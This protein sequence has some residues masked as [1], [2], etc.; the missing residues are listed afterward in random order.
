MPWPSQQCNDVA[1]L[2]LLL[3]ENNIARVQTSPL[4]S[5]ESIGLCSIFWNYI[6]TRQKSFQ[7]LLLQNI[8]I[9]RESEL[10]E[11]NWGFFLWFC[12]LRVLW[13]L[14]VDNSSLNC[15]ILKWSGFQK[16]TP[17]LFHFSQCCE[18]HYSNKHRRIHKQDYLVWASWKSIQYC[19]SCRSQWIW[20]VLWA[21]CAACSFPNFGSNRKPAIIFHEPCSKWINWR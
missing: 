14:Q 8:C 1:I 11:C 19:F 5:F 13:L 3:R 10:G 17:R 20:F 18:N 15:T 16:S 7:G 6:E 12:H 9:S 4:F 21:V 2:Q